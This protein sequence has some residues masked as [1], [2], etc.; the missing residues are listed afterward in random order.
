MIREILH[1]YGKNQ[2][3]VIKKRDQNVDFKG[4]N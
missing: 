3:K 2:N 4:Y 1:L